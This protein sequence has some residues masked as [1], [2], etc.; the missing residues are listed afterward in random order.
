MGFPPVGTAPEFYIIGQA[1]TQHKNIATIPVTY[2]ID[3][4]LQTNWSELQALHQKTLRYFTTILP[5]PADLPSNEKSLLLFWLGTEA[6][7]KQ[8]NGAAGRRSFIVNYVYGKNHRISTSDNVHSLLVTAHEQFHQYAD[9]VRYKHPVDTSVWI[10]ESLAQYYALKSMQKTL[11]TEEYKTIKKKFL[12]S[13]QNIK[14][15]FSKI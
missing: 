12:A 7:N 2:V 5:L 3:N 13:N 4:S 6:K 8:V 10:E 15:K 9:M 11:S 14:L 1:E